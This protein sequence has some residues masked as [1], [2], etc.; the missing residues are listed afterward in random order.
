MIEEITLEL[1]VWSTSC[2]EP[3][4][5]KTYTLQ[6]MLTI[7]KDKTNDIVIE[8]SA[9]SERHGIL[10]EEENRLR[11]VESRKVRTF[12][13]LYNGKGWTTL[14]PCDVSELVEGSLLRLGQL[15]PK[16]APSVDIHVINIKYSPQKNIPSR[17]V[18]SDLKKLT[19]QRFK[20]AH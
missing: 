11:Y 1:K 12:S 19:K 10:Y 15:T 2:L 7:G 14:D 9:L 18:L 3:A 4:Q 17:K 20:P 16:G 5:I 8:N 6:D 13:Y